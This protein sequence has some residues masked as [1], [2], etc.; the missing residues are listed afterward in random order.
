MKVLVGALAAT[1]LMGAAAAFAQP[2]TTTTA[3]AAVQPAA[4]PAPVPP[5]RC[6]SIPEPPAPPD[7][8]TANSAAWN[9]AAAAYNAWAPLMEANLACRRTEF[10]E[11]RAQTD[12]RKAE[13]DAAVA[14]VRTTQTAWDA[15]QAAYNARPARQRR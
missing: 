12:A 7:G 4:P 13:H 1:L 6:P 9:V 2:T 8:A 10:N 3:P 11:L 15:Q 14:Q 5:T